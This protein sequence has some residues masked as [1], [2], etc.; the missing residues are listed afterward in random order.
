[1]RGRRRRVCPRL[2]MA[3]MVVSVSSSCIDSD[4]PMS[5]ASGGRQPAL[6]VTPP[7]PRGYNA[8][9]MTDASLARAALDGDPRAFTLLVDRHAPA[10]IRFA[11]R[12]LGNREDAED[13]AQESFLRAYRALE[14]YDESKT[15]RTW[16]MTILVNRCR[17]AML[18]RHRR[19]RRVVASESA[20][21]AAVAPHANDILLR[22]AIEKALISLDA[23]QREAFLLKHVEQLEYEEM[24]TV[25][26]ASVS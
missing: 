18:L 20:V 8:A 26:G 7:E 21:Q 9:V 6:V 4:A 24:A 5:R 15:F 19:E 13:V 12:M 11:T 25:T 3:S 2:T 10:C 16:L 1:M 22:D 14:S 23:D 17:S